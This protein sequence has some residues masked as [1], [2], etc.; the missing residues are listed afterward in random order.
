MGRNDR[1]KLGILFNVSRN[2]LGGVYYIINIIKALDTLD[3]VD[4]PEILVFYNEELKDFVQEI[5]YSHLTLERWEFESPAKGYIKSWMTGKNAFT[6]NIVKT[7][8]L[9]GLY[10]EWNIPI[11]AKQSYDNNSN[12]KSIS[13]FA[14]FQHKY[15]P[16]FFS[17]KQLLMRELR[18]RFILRNASDLVVSSK[19]AKKDLEK[20][21]SLRNDLNIHVLNFVSIIDEFHFLPF[22]DLRKNYGIPEHY[23][24]VSNQF[25][26]HKNHE[27]LFKALAKLKKNGHPVNFVVTGKMP[28]KV[29]SPY[30][31]YL[32]DL[33][34]KYRL[35]KYVYFLGV[36]P[37][38]DQLGLMKYSK[39]V[40]QPSLFEGW[41]TVIEDAKSLQV[42]VIASNL[43]VNIEQ[44]GDAGKYFDPHNE[45]ELA[46]ILA[47]HRK[48]GD[49]IYDDYHGRVRAFAQ[50]FLKMFHD[51]GCPIS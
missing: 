41:S 6:N 1:L 36:I 3:E 18:L 48:N 45:S 27:I 28:A 34:E 8:N 50:N 38:N 9:D 13:W 32:Y 46:G 30:I 22:S 47:S 16:E 39:A 23:F 20:F 19:S 29:N 49:R 15:Y 10:P 31:Q 35:K 42:P 33:I 14:D 21:Y 17:R 5:E 25:H 51:T 4:K 26:K 11:N 2:W 37:R 40:I 7:F 44:L 12:V 43:D 24:I